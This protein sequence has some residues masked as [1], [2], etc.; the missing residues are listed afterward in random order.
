MGDKNLT[1]IIQVLSRIVKL[2]S[3]LLIVRAIFELIALLIVDLAVFGDG[4]LIGF[5][6]AS[7]IIEGTG[8]FIMI[9]VALGL[10]SIERKRDLGDAM[11]GSARAQIRDDANSQ[12]PRL[13]GLG[14]DSGAEGTSHKHYSLYSPPSIDRNS[15]KLSH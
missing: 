7:V 14:A 10:G 4:A 9:T 13:Y 8:F 6:L 3:P 12:V 5:R 1:F 2:I 15:I 11:I